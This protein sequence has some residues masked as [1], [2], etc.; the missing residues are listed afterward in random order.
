MIDQSPSLPA[1]LDAAARAA[2]CS[3][4][5]EGSLRAIEP[6]KRGHINDTFL[7]TWQASGGVRRFVHQ[8]VNH[9]VFKNVPAVMQ[10]IARITDHL[11]KKIAARG[12]AEQ[13]LTLVPSREGRDFIVDRAGNY[14][15]TYHYI[16]NTVAYDVCPNSSVALQVGRA[17]GQFAADLADFDAAALHEPIA[18]FQNVGR[19]LVNLEDAARR[20]PVKRAASA[21]DELRQIR[22]FASAVDA[23]T[24]AIESG[25][26]PQRATHG[27]TKYNN[28]LCHAFTFEPVCVVDLDTCMR[29]TLLYDFGDMIRTGAV[30]APEDEKDLARVFL[31]QALFQAFAQGYVHSTRG[32]LTPAELEYLPAAPRAVTLAQ[33]ARFLADYLEGDTYYKISYPDHNLVRARTQIKAVKSM[34]ELGRWMRETVTAS[35]GFSHYRAQKKGT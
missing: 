7:S 5:I 2:A 15:R 26:I 23:M 10:N 8:R 22:A 34:E 29:G 11:R 19:R 32:M 12:G 25:A 1:S 27:D 21:R 33:A 31:D 6:L 3:F 30:P 28:V 4:A 13:V 9:H 20:D 14:W 35:C 18:Q 17:F 24:S 16:E